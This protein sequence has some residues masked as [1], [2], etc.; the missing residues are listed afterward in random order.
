VQFV[1]SFSVCM[2][3]IASA[4]FFIHGKLALEA[5]EIIF[6]NKK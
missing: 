6:N 5:V 1:S 3:Q 2:L 4:A